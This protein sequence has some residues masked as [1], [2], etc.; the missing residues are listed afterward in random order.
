MKEKLQDLE[1]RHMEELKEI[2]QEQEE[3]V[4]MI[5][6]LHGKEMTHLKNSSNA[7]LGKLILEYNL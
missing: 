3:Q 7:A 5:K 6:E 4:E 1:R 2:T